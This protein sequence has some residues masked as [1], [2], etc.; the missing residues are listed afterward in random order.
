MA[1]QLV[2]SDTVAE[3]IDKCLPTICFHHSLNYRP[4]GYGN[5]HLTVMKTRGCHE[6][7][8]KKENANST[9]SN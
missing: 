6:G 7:K 3:R 5:E 1:K 9:T 4:Q 2:V 8:D